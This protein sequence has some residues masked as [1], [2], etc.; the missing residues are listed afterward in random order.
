[1]KS[2]KYCKNYQNVTQKHEVSK[3]C[4]EN[5]TDRLASRKVARNLQF[6]KNAVPVKNKKA[7]CNKMRYKKAKCNKMRYA[8]IL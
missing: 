7:K 8:C 3:C 5:G 6:V 1:M 4:W 2:L